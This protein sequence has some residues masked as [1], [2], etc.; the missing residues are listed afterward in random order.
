MSDPVSNLRIVRD[1]AGNAGYPNT[2]TLGADY[3]IYE[4]V[5]LFAEYEDASGTDIDAT[6]SRLGVRA[7]PWARAQ[8]NSSITSQT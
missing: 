4:G 1:G 7:T 8:V 6:M 5:E 2:L 3:R